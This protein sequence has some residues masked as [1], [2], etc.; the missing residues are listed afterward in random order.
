MESL[1]DTSRP[2]PLWCARAISLEVKMNQ[3]PNNRPQPAALFK[4]YILQSI[5]GAYF[6]TF[7][8]S[9]FNEKAARLHQLRIREQYREDDSAR[10]AGREPVTLP[11]S[12]TADQLAR[13]HFEHAT[14]GFRYGL[15]TVGELWKEYRKEQIS[16]I[17]DLWF[18][19]FPDC[20]I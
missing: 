11:P 20:E 18:E 9:Y 19:A 14:F 6:G 7:S 15:A 12:L 4:V 16:S 17:R 2:L 13:A 8:M 1:R 3:L 5:H 10:R